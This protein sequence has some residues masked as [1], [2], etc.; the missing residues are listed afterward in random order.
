MPA[1]TRSFLTLRTPGGLCRC[2]R[3]LALG[4]PGQAGTVAQDQPT[5]TTPVSE[6]IIPHPP[7]SRTT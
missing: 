6:A 7:T 5:H 4:I 3:P 2:L 1:D